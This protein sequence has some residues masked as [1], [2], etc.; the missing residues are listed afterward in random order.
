M[1]YKIASKEDTLNYTSRKDIN[2]YKEIIKEAKTKLGIQTEIVVNLAKWWRFDCEEDKYI[3]NAPPFNE[4]F[5]PT[6]LHYVC[7]A[8]I[9]DEGWLQPA[10]GHTFTDEVFRINNLDKKKWDTMAKREK[11]TLCFNFINRAADSFFD[12]FVWQFVTKKYGKQYLLR[13]IGP[14]DDN[15]VNAVISKFQYIHNDSGFKYF[16]YIFTLD[17]FAMF[18]VLTKTIDP[19]T[20]NRLE[21]VY[22]DLLKNPD[23]KALVIPNIHEKIISLRKFYTNL[24]AK[25]PTFKEFLADKE[26]AKQNF[27]RY[28]EQVWAGTGLNV[29]VDHFV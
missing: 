5:V 1:K 20:H 9:L 11:E 12:F 14:I 28:Y 26:Q 21:K 17:Y 4:Q 24:Q 8:K 25:Y 10:I 18:Y 2:P 22:N 29:T 7:H 15:S 23:F 19:D 16:N 3:I 13:V 27:T 6:F